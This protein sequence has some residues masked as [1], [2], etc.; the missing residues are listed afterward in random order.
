MKKR[1]AEAV[2]IVLVGALDTKGEDFR[3]VKDRIESEGLGTF[4]IDVGI[5]G[6]PAFRPD[7][8]SA[9][10]AIAGGSRID[11]LRAHKDKTESM[12]VMTKGATAIVR[13][14][15]DESRLH[16][17]L[18]M[19]GTGGTAVASACM[20][21]LPIGIPKVLVSTAG[22]GDMSAFLGFKDITVFPSIV[23][24]A[25]VNRISRLLYANAA[26]AIAGMARKRSLPASD[27]R[28]LIAA[29]MFGN[30][31]PCVERA[32]AVLEAGSNEVLVFHATGTGGKAMVSLCEEGLLAGVLDITTTELADEVCGGVFSAGL[33]RVNMGAHRPVP[34]V[35]APGCVDMCNFWGPDTIPP[36]YR[37]RQLYEW[38]PNVTLMRTNV[39]ENVRIGELI[40]ETA[41][42]C[43]GKVVILL[44]MKG[45]SMLDSE[46]QPFWD[47]EADAACYAAI[48][49]TAKPGTPIVEV[50]A[51]I[52]DPRF[53]NLAAADLLGMLEHSNARSQSGVY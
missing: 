41:N 6:E 14:L 46:G 37:N 40:A 28:P 52:N 44:P 3:F 26:A 29:S 43:T 23:D 22:S 5:L 53:A 9:D 35:I 48:R 11:L 17:I 42:A 34:I 50:D 51:N 19:G 49:R 30:T 7:I 18:G 24:V 31:T 45:V 20:R 39:E 1:T 36:K 33:C 16:G 27:D 38:N 4:V 47:E 2:Q 25:G 13:Q 10:I 15:Y 12:R 32:K 21:L 8:S